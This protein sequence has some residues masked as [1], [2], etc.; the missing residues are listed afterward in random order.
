MTEYGGI[1]IMKTIRISA[2][3]VLAIFLLSL[4]VGAINMTPSVE[5]K[6]GPEL[7]EGEDDLIITPVKDVHD[8]DKDVH[9]D[10]EE[11]LRDTVEELESKTWDEIYHE[12]DEKWHETTEGAPREHAVVSDIFDVRYEGEL[13]T[14]GEGKT[15]TFKIKVQGIDKDDLFLII[16][17]C[18]EKEDWKLVEYTIDENGVITITG[19][20]KASYVIVSDN[21]SIPVIGP[22]DPISPPTAVLD[23]FPSALGIAFVAIIVAVSLVAASKKET[24]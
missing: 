1:N 5:I 11:S 10:I 19:S 8:E 17:R 4:G 22:D 15:V 21:G 12:F 7:V 3:A 18:S 24:A 9:D 13:S 14:D 6:D 2:L 16:S 23:Y 20:T